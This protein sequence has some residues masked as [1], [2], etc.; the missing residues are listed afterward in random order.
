MLMKIFTTL[1]LVFIPAGTQSGARGQAV[2]SPAVIPVPLTKLEAFAAKTGTLLATETYSLLGIYGEHSCNIRVQVIIMY[3]IGR[4]A[5][6][7]QGLRVEIADST[8]KNMVA[9]YIDLDELENL[10]KAINSMLDLN[11]QGTSFTNPASKELFFS[12]TGGL[13]IAMVQR[14]TEK[15]LIV[16]HLFAGGS[17]VVNRDTS[18]IELKTGID[19]VLQDLR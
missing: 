12:S 11:R 7:V 15:K 13:K 10:S 19:K 9:A 1:L 18:V 17:C 5:E 16:T 4:E 6:K 14:D 3:E 8:R 2:I